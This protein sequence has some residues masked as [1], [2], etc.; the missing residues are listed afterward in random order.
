VDQTIGSFLKPL[1]LFHAG[2]GLFAISALVSVG[3]SP[4]GSWSATCFDTGCGYTGWINS[5]YIIPTSG[6]YYLEVGTVNWD[7]QIFD[8]GLAMDG[9]TVGGNPIT[10]TNNPAAYRDRCR[11]TAAEAPSPAGVATFDPIPKKGHFYGT[12][13]RGGPLPFYTLGG[14][15]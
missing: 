13:R 12:S 7:D 1:R 9:A 5:N 10:G 3:G 4:L 8:S 2:L 15:M 11:S 14:S 6:N